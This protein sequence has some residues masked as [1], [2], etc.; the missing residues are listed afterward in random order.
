MGEVDR[1]GRDRCMIDYDYL[2]RVIAHRVPELSEND[3]AAAASQPAP[4][5]DDTVVP[6][7]V[8]DQVLD[9]IIAL[10][11]RMSKLEEEA[12][13]QRSDSDPVGAC[14]RALVDLG[15]RTSASP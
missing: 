11:G 5:D 4:S 14:R 1:V 15:W 12:R 6:V 9:L 3:L 10:E 7:E 13:A 8:L 2:N